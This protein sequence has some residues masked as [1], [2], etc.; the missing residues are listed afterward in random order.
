MDKE[1]KEDL[2]LKDLFTGSVMEKVDKSIKY[3]QKNAGAL[4]LISTAIIALGSVVIKLIYYLSDLGYTH[5]FGISK[6]LIDVSKGNIIYSFFADGVIALFL[7]FLNFI[8]YK[9]WKNKK[10]LKAKIVQLLI[11]FLLFP[12]MLFPI[13]FWYYNSQNIECSFIYILVFNFVLSFILFSFS[14]CFLFVKFITDIFVKIVKFI[15]DIFVKLIKF[16]TDIFNKSYV[17]K[18]NLRNKKP[19]RL[20]LK[21]VNINKFKVEKEDENQKL[22]KNLK[23]KLII[24]GIGIVVEASIMTFCG[25]QRAEVLN[26]FKILEGTSE[27]VNYAVIYETSDNF[28]ITECTIDDEAKTIKIDKLGVK[29]EID[30]KGVEYTIKRLTQ[31]K[32]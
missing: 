29:K 18:K 22:L 14:F 32:G 21:K 17:R 26:K 25:Y 7:I 23:D 15:T 31:I 9:A 4:S 1:N 19:R 30:R 20:N 27:N 24:I 5:Y 2:H 3:I 16:I 12:L 11:I 13:V 6:E 28:I 10:G 8:S